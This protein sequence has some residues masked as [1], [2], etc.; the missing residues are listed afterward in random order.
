MKMISIFLPDF[1]LKALD[2]LILENYF[3]NRA[4]AIRVAIRDFIKSEY[5]MKQISLIDEDIK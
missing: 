2:Q 5:E 1:Y 4:E 3:P